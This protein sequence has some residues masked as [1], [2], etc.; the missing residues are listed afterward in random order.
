M[1]SKC[2]IRKEET[3]IVTTNLSSSHE[4]TYPHIQ[5]MHA[6]LH[7]ARDYVMHLSLLCQVGQRWG[8]DF[9]IYSEITGFVSLLVIAM[10][11]G[12]EFERIHYHC[13]LW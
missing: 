7:D 9:K 11:P 8:L 10:Q 2:S 3:K 4:P 5:G 6:G 12:K 13:I 1:A